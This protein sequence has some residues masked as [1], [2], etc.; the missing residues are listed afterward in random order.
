[1]MISVHLNTN[2]TGYPT[3]GNDSLFSSSYLFWE[4]SECLWTG[5]AGSRPLWSGLW[6]VRSPLCR[7]LLSHCAIP[8]PRGCPTVRQ[9][10]CMSPH[11]P[12]SRA[13]S[14]RWSPGDTSARSR[15]R[16][17][18]CSLLRHRDY[19]GTWYPR[20]SVWPGSHLWIVP[21][22]KTIYFSR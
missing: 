11:Q 5:Q 15:A 17:S 8:R 19:L 3:Q 12:W 6:A 4:G 1:M 7:Y 20:T 13:H 2:C 9:S 10:V 16:Y 21:E 22:Q 14:S 18:T